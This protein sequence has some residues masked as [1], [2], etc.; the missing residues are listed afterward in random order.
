[1]AGD[2]KPNPLVL[3]R[4]HRK[5][6]ITPRNGRASWQDTLVFSGL[7]LA[8]GIASVVLGW[9]LGTAASAGLLTASGLLGAFLFGVMLQ[10]FERATDWADS[11]PEPGEATSVH[12]RSLR[13][14]AANSGYASLICIAAAVAYVVATLTA[15]WTLRVCTAIGLALG[16]HLVLV[17]LMVMKRVYLLIEGRLNRAESGADRPRPI[18][19]HRRKAS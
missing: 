10:V 6:L 3:I 14:L 13:E 11:Q 7:P 1:M 17:L 2:A 8:I 15:G 19:S 4:A 5:T 18:I 16:V 9:E 12:A